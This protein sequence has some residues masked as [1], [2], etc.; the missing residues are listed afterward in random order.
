M[1]ASLLKKSPV[2]TFAK[3]DGVS[4]QNSQSLTRQIIREARKRGVTAIKSDNGKASIFI[5]G[6]V[7]FAANDQDRAVAYVWDFSNRRKNK[8]HRVSGEDIL[9]RSRSSDNAKSLSAK[10]IQRIAARTA[11]G[12]AAWLGRKGYRVREVS[13]PPPGGVRNISV[14]RAEAKAIATRET[15]A[16]NLYRATI[17]TRNGAVELSQPQAAR[18]SFAIPLQASEPT[19]T[20]SVSGPR[21]SESKQFYTTVVVQSVTGASNQGNAELTQAIK[22]ALRSKGVRVT[23]R[24]NPLSLQL[25]GTV[26][27]G[28]VQNRRRIIDISWNL[29]KSNGQGLGMVRQNNRVRAASVANSWGRT[30]DVAARAAATDIAKIVPRLT[31]T[32]VYTPAATNQ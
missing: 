25:V 30:A 31:A 28:P 10:N 9:P 29:K 17:P 20:G 2:V 4:A 27:M 13:L 16:Q 12:L 24:K 1:P 32:P 23:D 5:T 8:L 21:S 3:I 19:I 14:V 18:P 6:T 7:K 15:F 22:R 26:K 11:G